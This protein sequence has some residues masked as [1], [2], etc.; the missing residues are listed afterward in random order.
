MQQRISKVQYL[1][2]GNKGS[3]QQHMTIYVKKH[4]AKFNKDLMSHA[5]N[6]RNNSRFYEITNRR[7]YMQSIL[8]HC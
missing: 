8:F 4:F 7:S 1:S 6:M 2:T 3:P 5:T